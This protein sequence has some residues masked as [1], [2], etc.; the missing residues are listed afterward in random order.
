M[1]RTLALDYGRARCG[2]AL[3]DPSGSIVTPLPVVERPA[4]RRGLAALATLATENDVGRVVVGL[5]LTLD[6]EEGAQAAETRAFSEQLAR[7]LGDVQMDFY[8]ER[9]TTVQAARDGGRAA[10]E[11]SRAAAHLLEGYLAAQERASRSELP[12]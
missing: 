11:D 3:A 8:D 10:A 6:G 9:L 5:P 1:S 7:R 12:S 4:T 2:C